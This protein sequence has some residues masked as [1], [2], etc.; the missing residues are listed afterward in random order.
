MGRISK[1][2]TLPEPG[3]DRNRQF[4]KNVSDLQGQSREH[5]LTT[6]KNNFV[7]ERIPEDSGTP[8]VDDLHDAVL[9]DDH[10]VELQ[11]AMGE[12]HAV[13]VGHSV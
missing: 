2:R 7:L 3:T 4:L 8:E 1:G 12:T 11:I 13:E 5:I 6:S 10:I 9:I